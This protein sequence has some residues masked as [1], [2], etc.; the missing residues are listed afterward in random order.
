MVHAACVG[1]VC[2][3]SD[4]AVPRLD[5]SFG[6]WSCVWT[7]PGIPAGLA[8]DC[9][10][11]NPGFHH[12]QVLHTAALLMYWLLVRVVVSG[13]VKIL[14]SMACI[15]PERPCPAFADRIA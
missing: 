5:L 14:H 2:G 4:S 10:W 13:L 8:G 15:Y 3:G 12:W 1:T 11:S 7:G 6:C 9:A